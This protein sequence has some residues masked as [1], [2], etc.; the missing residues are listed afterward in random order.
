MAKRC[1]SINVLCQ[2]FLQKLISKTLA[3][4]LW[5]ADKRSG[6]FSKLYIQNKLQNSVNVV[7]YKENINYIRNGLRFYRTN[8]GKKMKE[9]ITS[10]EELLDEIVKLNNY[11]EMVILTRIP[12]VDILSALILTQTVS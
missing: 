10:K 4:I 5:D 7:E 11:V 9:F 12:A 2:N 3:C 8:I 6:I 1:E